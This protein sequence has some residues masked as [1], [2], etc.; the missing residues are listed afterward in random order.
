MSTK[1]IL[2]KESDWQLVQRVAKHRSPD[3]ELRKQA[4]DAMAILHEKY[5]EQLV[6]VNYRAI[7]KIY[8]L[9]GHLAPPSFEDMKDLASDTFL[10]LWS[11]AETF[12][13]H[14]GHFVPW[15]CQISK[16]LFRSQKKKDFISIMD[17]LEIAEERSEIFRRAFQDQEEVKES[18]ELETVTVEKTVTNE[19]IVVVEM[20]NS[21]Y[22]Y[23][24][25]VMEDFMNSLNYSDL[26]KEFIWDSFRYYDFDLKRPR[27]PKDRIAYYESKGLNIKSAYVKVGRFKKKFFTYGNQII[28]TRN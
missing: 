2:S 21:K 4:S 10:K 22:E 18:E 26:F 6:K 19:T 8:I 9:I 23:N 15:M 28:K 24:V 20:M 11:V 16:N 14:P 7:E 1:S 3:P 5:Y 27:L 13:E 12:N 17:M 25:T